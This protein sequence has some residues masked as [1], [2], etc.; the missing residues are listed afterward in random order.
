SGQLGLDGNAKFG[1]PGGQFIAGLSSVAL[2][3]GLSGVGSAGVSSATRDNKFHYGTNM[4]YQAG[5]HLIKFGGQLL[6]IQQN[7]YYSGNNGALGLFSYSAVYSG[8]DFGDFLLDAL[9]RKGRGGVGDKWGHRHWRNALFA[10]DDIK[11]RPN[12]TLN[13]GIRWEYVTPIYEV[14]DR[15]VNIDVFTGELI[16]PGQNSANR[17]LYEPYHKQFMPRIGFAW[18]PAMF[19]N[20]LVIRSGY[21]F[22]NFLEGT[23]ANLRLPLNPPFFTE[24]DVT[25]DPA[26]AGTITTGFGD[27]AAVPSLAGPRTGAPNAQ[28]QPTPFLQAR[29]WERNL[30]PQF[31]NQFNFALE[32]Q[33]DSVTS[34]SAAYVGQRGTHLVV[35]HEANNPLP[36]TGPVSTW[37]DLND[38]RPLAR[39][40]PNVSNIA[41]T[42]SSG[43]MWYNSLQTYVRRRYNR[44][45]ELIA[46]YTL[47]KTNTDNLGYYGCGNVN[48][49]GAYWQDAYNRHGNY[50]P[51]C[52]DARH[53]FTTGGLYELPIGK[54]KTWGSGWSRPLDLVLGGWNVN[55]FL[56][57][58][59]GFPVTIQAAS[60]NTGGRTPRGNVRANRY[61][62]LDLSGT[63]TVDSW[64]GKVFTASD[65]CASG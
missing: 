12:F 43:T 11:L 13:L 29:A 10:Q 53:N 14:A 24:I 1:I 36:G 19:N 26:R 47:S 57:A 51:A 15:Q 64:F 5:Q 56:S 32:Y 59:S 54:G 8:I 52:F 25:Y 7:R 40:L 62:P 2:G 38:R 46:Q 18:T 6:R 41:L 60:H 49:E 37:I 17:A 48:S 39:A 16:F 61:G 30:R 58:H 55:Y 42:E 9:T 31:T 34:I 65:F 50:G 20:K 33:I 44:R 3:G 45:L 22:T 4:T 35:P 23:G 27:V 21:A 63:R 28:G